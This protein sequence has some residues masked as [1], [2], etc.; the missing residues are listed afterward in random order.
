MCQPIKPNQHKRPIRPPEKT[1]RAEGL[2][3]SRRSLLQYSAIGLANLA[4]A[5]CAQRS[6]TGAPKPSQSGGNSNNSVYAPILATVSAASLPSFAA[7]A[8]QVKVM[9]DGTYY[10][11]ES[12]G[13]PTHP[14]MIGIRSWQQQVPLPQPFSGSN[15][16]S[17]PIK[18]ILAANPISARTALYRGAIALAVN[19]IPIFNAL[20]NRG[21][22]AYVFGELDDWGGHCGR[23]DDY[24]YHT[25]PLHLQTYIGVGNPI[26]YALD[27][28][29]LYGLTEADGSQPVGLDEFNGHGDKDGSY[30]YHAT[31]TYP[32]INGGMRG[33]VQVK[34]DQIEP[35]PAMTAIRAAQQPLRGATIS[36]FK[37]VD[38]NS[39]AL[40]YT[41]NG[42]T[43]YV[44]YH[45]EADTYT[46]EFID[47][48]GVRRIEVYKRKSR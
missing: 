3:L 44:N 47:A 14:M 6:A 12:N 13:L 39:Y 4:L 16:F 37:N 41:L 31:T 23:A 48:N 40:E 43:N 19:G 8:D 9:S 25:A 7:F 11:I 42:K 27:G 32:Y 45:F 17:I 21:D 5:A 15:A 38:I 22:D 33:V 46:F 28:F 1:H 26:A 18:P 36:N 30:H 35:Q 2:H 10:R 29:P 20:N 24:H 34:D